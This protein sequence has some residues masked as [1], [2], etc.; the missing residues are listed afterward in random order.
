MLLPH[1][2]VVTM[3][4]KAEAGE[5]GTHISQDDFSTLR[6][7]EVAVALPEHTNAALYFIGTI[8]TPWRSISSTCL[9]NFCGR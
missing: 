1:A 7:G 5:P 8:R 4:G 9:R 6:E 2:T 3:S